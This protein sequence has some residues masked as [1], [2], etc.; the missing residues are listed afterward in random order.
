MTQTL[1][2]HVFVYLRGFLC[3]DSITSR[4][5]SGDLQ[6]FIFTDGGGKLEVA[7]RR[8]WDLCEEYSRLDKIEQG[9]ISNQ[10][11][12]IVTREMWNPWKTFAELPAARLYKT[13]SETASTSL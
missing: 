7:A 4:T 2:S 9:F 12:T 1:V 13:W 11:I 10:K 3:L 5:G 6:R 8:L